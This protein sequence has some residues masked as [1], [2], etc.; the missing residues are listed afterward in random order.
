[1]LC[2]GA[3]MELNIIPSSGYSKSENIVRRLAREDDEHD[4]S[5]LADADSSDEEALATR[6]APPKVAGPSKMKKETESM[7][8]TLVH[9]D[10][11]MLSG[12]DFEVSSSSTLERMVTD[13]IHSIHC[14]GQG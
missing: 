14:I 12:D 5:D 4:D 8:F 10:M 11:L 1:M 13:D 3:D 6:F 2:L 9:G 7:F